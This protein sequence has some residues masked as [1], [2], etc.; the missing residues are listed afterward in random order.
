MNVRL[1]AFPAQA[2]NTSEGNTHAPKY[3]WRSWRPVWDRLPAQLQGNRLTVLS[4][5]NVRLLFE[6]QKQLLEVLGSVVPLLGLNR[7]AT[8]SNRYVVRFW[9]RYSSH[10]RH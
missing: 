8:I 10:S 5:L 9:S 1:P 6:L 3:P 2:P 4:V 7:H